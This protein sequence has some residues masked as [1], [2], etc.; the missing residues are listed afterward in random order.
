MM[1]GNRRV[2]DPRQDILVALNLNT[3][4]DLPDRNAGRTRNLS[5][6]LERLHRDVLIRLVDQ[7]VRTDDGVDARVV[8]R[9]GDIAAR[10]RRH[11]G[12]VDGDVL[13]GPR[14]GSH[15]TGCG[16]VLDFRPVRWKLGECR[17]I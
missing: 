8:G 3:R 2:P 11:K 10:E 1:N 13:T 16:D 9:D 6:P 17:E 15:D 12:D 14:A 4:R 5:G 7:P